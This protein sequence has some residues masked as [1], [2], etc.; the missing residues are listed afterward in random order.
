M[1]SLQSGQSD[2][3]YF[4]GASRSSNNTEE[5]WRDYLVNNSDEAYAGV[6]GE[7]ETVRTDGRSRN[8]HAPATSPVRPSSLST[9]A[10]KTP[11][12]DSDDDSSSGGGG[13][14][15]D[16]DDDDDN[17]ESSSDDEEQPREWTEEPG[18]MGIDE[19]SDYLC[20]HATRPQRKVWQGGRHTGRHFLGC[21]MEEAP[22]AFVVWQDE[23]WDERAQK[24]INE[25]WETQAVSVRGMDKFYRRL[26]RMAVRTTFHHGMAGASA[27]KIRRAWM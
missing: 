15:D 8:H 21:Q 11:P 4:S 2:S 12:D 9:L 1:S 22:Y 20:D 25:L 26:M 13:D 18:W 10:R 6:R 17:D 7:G 16:D 27:G 5:E 23:P 19:D 24:T 14:D 3:E